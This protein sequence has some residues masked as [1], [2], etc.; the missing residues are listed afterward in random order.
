M[1]KLTQVAS[2]RFIETGEYCGQKFHLYS[3]WK[4]VGGRAGD[5]EVDHPLK[6]V[7]VNG[8]GA[9]IK[10]GK[11]S[12]TFTIRETPGMFKAR[13]CELTS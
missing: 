5:P 6:Y 8:I 1:K 13:K 2:Q 11:K 12:L 7:A 3:E 4:F 9:S 10:H